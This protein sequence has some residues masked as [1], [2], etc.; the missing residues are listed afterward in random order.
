MSDIHER[1]L[2][3]IVAEGVSISKFERILEVGKNSLSTTLRRKSAISHEVII[4][5]MN[6]YPKYS[7]YWLVLGVNESPKEQILNQ[8]TKLINGK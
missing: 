5:I 8:I 1:I 7:L 3:I 2:K 4:K 6:K